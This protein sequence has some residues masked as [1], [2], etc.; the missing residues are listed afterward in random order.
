[1]LERTTLNVCS[2]CAHLGTPVR[3][4]PDTQQKMSNN[5]PDTRDYGKSDRQA[6]KSPAR[7][8]QRPPR[9]VEVEVSEDYP[10]I[11]RAGRQNAGLSQDELAKKVSERVTVIKQLERGDLFPEDK[12]RRKLEKALGVSLLESD[13]TFEDASTTESGGGGGLTLGDMIQIKKK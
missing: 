1:M 13:E 12:V 4:S 8:N 6:S 2:G 9:R 10:Q 7:S 5:A 3:E 11:L